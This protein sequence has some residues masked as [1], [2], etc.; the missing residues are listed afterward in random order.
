MTVS[1]SG[2][3]AARVEVD[4]GG[5]RV[6][7]SNLDKVLWPRLGLT[8]RWLVG[9]YT[10]VAPVLL[11]HLAGHPVTFHRFPDGVDG[12]NWY[13]TRAPA[14]PDW[15]ETVTFHMRRTGKV[16]DVCVL[17]DLAALVWAAQIAAI[18]LHPYL[19]KAERLDRPDV[20]VFDLD[21]GP[22]ATIVECCR[23]ALWLREALAGVA[24]EAWPKTSGGAGLHV[25]VPLHTGA[26]YDETKAFARA[27]AL[28]LERQDPAAVTSQMR[29]AQR[30][31][32]V[33]VDWS[34]NDAG[35]ST[36]AP[37]SLRGHPA[38]AVS[39]PITWEEVEAAATVGDPAA[40]CF[41][42]HDA[43]DRIRSGDLFAPVA[44]LEQELPRL[45]P[46]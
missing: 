4:A 32:K 10:E 6:T 27:V 2:D 22:P 21:P 45:P 37:Y 42:A 1:S 43:L 14:H 12:V 31:G 36:V 3:R 7:L 46:R 28:S 34:Q 25:Y 29:R 33:F 16:F 30:A 8:K 38:P 19:A 35:K 15:V 40:L 44:S 9:Y 26:T 41:L 39:L 20:V 13:E 17:N 5:R 18:E 23:I 24:L 11:P